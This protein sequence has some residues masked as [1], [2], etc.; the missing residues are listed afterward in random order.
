M[1]NR[2]MPWNVLASRDFGLFWSSLLV[3]A[4]GSQLTEVT[5]TCNDTAGPGR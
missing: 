3:S 5:G 1:K 4:I 2:V